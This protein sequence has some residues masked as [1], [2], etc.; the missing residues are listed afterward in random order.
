MHYIY[1]KYK[2]S[3]KSIPKSVTNHRCPILPRKFFSPKYFIQSF[4]HPFVYL[5]CHEQHWLEIE[6]EEEEPKKS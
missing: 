6:E 5:F 1:S 4:G 3:E 2:I